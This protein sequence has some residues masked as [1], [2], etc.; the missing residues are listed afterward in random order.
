MG[1]YLRQCTKLDL[2]L[3]KLHEIPS[4][5]LELPNL[6]DHELN[7]SHNNLVSIPDIPEWSAS[8][9]VLD[10]SYNHLSNLPGSAVA[11]ALKNH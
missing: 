2:Q 9:S 4:C 3:N 11:C 6:S 5:L 10:L 7:L 1:K 8:L